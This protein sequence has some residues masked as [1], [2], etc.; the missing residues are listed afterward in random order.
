MA[1]R[2]STGIRNLWA[3]QLEQS[4]GPSA[5]LR[6][7]SGLPP[8]IP[9]DPDSGTL[10]VGIVLPADWLTGPSSGQVDLLGVWS[11]TA[12]A[13]GDIG[14]FRI[15]NA[16]GTVCLMQGTVDEPGLGADMEIDFRGVAVGQLVICS[17]FSLIAPN[18]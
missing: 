16:A 9:E 5:L 14:Y 17:F 7:S 15:K 3:Q 13:I 18:A 8:A 1:V 6:L 10:L 4:A 2:F 12:I 11:G